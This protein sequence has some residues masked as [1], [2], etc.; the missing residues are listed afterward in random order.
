[1]QIRRLKSDSRT[2]ALQLIKQSG[3]NTI[4][5]VNGALTSKAS[6]LRTRWK[7]KKLQNKTEVI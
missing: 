1:M 2:L 6:S 7:I 4:K 3:Y 5:T